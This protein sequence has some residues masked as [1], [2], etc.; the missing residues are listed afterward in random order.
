MKSSNDRSS[1]GARAISLIFFLI[2]AATMAIL[3]SCGSE[4]SGEETKTPA[5]LDSADE[6]SQEIDEG[7]T[8][9]PV[10]I[11]MAMLPILD[12]L[13]M[14]VADEK[15]YFEEQN[16]LVEFVPVPSAS[17]RDQVI[18]AGQADGMINELL[19]TLFYNLDSQEIVVV[20]NARVAT[21]DYPQFRILASADSGI[22]DLDSLKGQEIGISK[23]TIIEYSTDRLLEAEGFSSEEINTIA[24][25]GIP[26]RMALLGSGE[27]SAANLPDPLSSLAMQGG[28]VVIVDDSKHP[29]YGHSTISFRKEFVDSQPEAVRGFLLAVE[30][31]VEDINADK[32]QFSELLSER[33]L[34]PAPLLGSY[35]IPDF[36]LAGVPPQSQWD[37]I[38]EWALS[39]GY[40]DADLAYDDSVD[41]SYLP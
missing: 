17:Q 30:K 5:N 41:D 15:G 10:T 16:L 39:K 37:D 36:P 33:Q 40:I 11:R 25:P 19:S 22:T 29:E 20:R 14:Y 3:A 26:D 12:A 35:E 4:E 9:E 32:D 13:P 23:A 21:S 27:L 34:V 18:Q 31:A 7:Q 24:V 6:T 1:L 38:L 8:A 2:L 28:A